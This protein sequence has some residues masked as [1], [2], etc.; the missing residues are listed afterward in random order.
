MRTLDS[1]AHRSMFRSFQLA[2]AWLP[3]ILIVTIATV[4]ARADII[5]TATSVV[6]TGTVSNSAGPVSV[7]ATLWTD[8]SL[9]GTLNLLLQNTSTAATIA[10]AGLL[11]S[12]YFG[13]YSGT[14]SGSAPGLTYVSGSGQV[15]QP[16][17]NGGDVPGVYVPP[18]SAGGS[19]TF[20]PFASG[21]SNLVATKKGDDTWQFRSGLSLVASEP[22][23]NFGIGTAGNNSLTP[24]NFNG[25]VVGGNDFG[26]SVGDASTQNLQSVGLLVRQSAW[27]RFAGFTAPA[28]TIGNIPNHAV[29][30]LGSGPDVI[31]SVPEPGTMPLA[32]IGVVAAMGAWL[33]RRIAMRRLDREVRVH[34]PKSTAIVQS[35]QSSISHRPRTASDSYR[36]VSPSRSSD[37]SAPSGSMIRYQRT[38]CA[39]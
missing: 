5:R 6:F 11:T 16:V 34:T 37:D 22:P 27:F 1:S 32:A 31:I 8:P 2:P 38:P 23:L 3:C 20:T 9:P 29:F 26:I 30:G 18:A 21:L 35:G 14:T 12:F 19:G 17:K 15:Y 7:Q 24:N 25:D 13:A 36:P 10:P 28:W 33:R 4:P 39:S